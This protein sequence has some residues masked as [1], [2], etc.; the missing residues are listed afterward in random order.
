MK[1]KIPDMESKNI[2][3]SPEFQWSRWPILTM[4]STSSRDCRSYLAITPITPKWNQRLTT[5]QVAPFADD[6][7]NRCLWVGTWTFQENQP[8]CNPIQ[9][10]SP[11]HGQSKAIFKCPHPIH[12]HYSSVHIQTPIQTSPT[13][14]HLPRLRIIIRS[15]VSRGCESKIP[16][17]FL[18]FARGRECPNLIPTRNHSCQSLQG[19]CVPILVTPSTVGARGQELGSIVVVYLSKSF[20]GL[21]WRGSD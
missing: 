4:W 11:I 6:R 5:V 15:S 8:G 13:T 9:N 7:N 21:L 2:T 10:P 14:L 16:S 1:L 17:F 18:P 3:V 12:R 20:T 19:V